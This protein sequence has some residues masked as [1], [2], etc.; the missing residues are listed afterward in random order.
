MTRTHV[1]APTQIVEANRMTLSP[2]QIARLDAAGAVPLG[3]PH[4][5]INNSASVTAGGML[6][7]LDRLSIPAA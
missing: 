3:T 6:E 4:E 2:G 5:Q 7:L 1:T